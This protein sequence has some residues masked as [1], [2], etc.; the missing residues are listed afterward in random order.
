MWQGRPRLREKQ[1]HDEGPHRLPAATRRG[2]QG[3]RPESQGT[4]PCRHRDVGLA[5][6]RTERENT[7][8]LFKPPSVLL[9][10]SGPR[11]PTQSL[12]FFNEGP[13]LFQS[14]LPS[15]H[16]AAHATL[17][18]A[19]CKRQHAEPAESPNTAMLAPPS[20]RI[21]LGNSQTPLRSP[22]KLTQMLP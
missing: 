1:L 2:K 16:P 19:E 22:G 18:R 11:T 5:G 9:C 20:P 7:F 15:G 17:L 3:F 8:P 4:R 13:N 10:Y 14:P 12:I 21:Y 6:S